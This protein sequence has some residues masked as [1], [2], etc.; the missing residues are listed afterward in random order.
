M[1]N[2]FAEQLSLDLVGFMRK[3][4][5]EGAH[6]SK[7]QLTRMSN[8][9]RSGDKSMRV[10]I[11]HRLHSILLALSGAR[12]DYGLLSFLKDTTK[13]NDVISVMF[14]QRKE[15]NDRRA[16][17]EEFDEAMSTEKKFR[18]PQQVLLIDKYFDEYAEEIMSENTDIVMKADYAGINLQNVFNKANTRLGG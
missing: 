17:E 3:D 12:T 8:G 15:E 1:K 14:R 7:S 11:A 6:I 2:K 18:S 13:H 10:A 5:A 9:E 16:I 4:V